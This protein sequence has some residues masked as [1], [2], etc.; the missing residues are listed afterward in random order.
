MTD[1]ADESQKIVTGGGPGG[2]AGGGVPRKPII[3][4]VDDEPHVLSAVTLDLRRR[5]RADYR[6]VTAGS[7]ADALDAARKLRQRGDVVALFL[8]DQRMPAMTGTEFL[9][10]ARKVHPEARK[11]LLTAYADTEAAIASI[12]QVGL[13]H[14]LMKPWDPPEQNLYP[15]LD[16]LLDDWAAAVRAPWDGIRVV[17]HAVV[18]RVPRDEGFPRAQPHPVPLAGSRSRRRGEGAFRD[19]ARRPARPAAAVLPRRH[20]AVG[21]RAPR[22]RREARPTTP[23]PRDS[24]TTWSSSAAGRPA[25]P[26]PCTARPRD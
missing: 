26:P 3:L 14:Y 25:S 2:A 16:D 22:D 15:V 19:P 5:F 17:G 7:G 10:A 6:I 8:A 11:V 4:A 24:S 9:A 13:D 12:N 18:G 1:P 23:R 21:A 20:R